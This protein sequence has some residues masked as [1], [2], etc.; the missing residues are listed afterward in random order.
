MNCPGSPAVLRGAI[1][2]QS[3]EGRGERGI[4]GRLGPGKIAYKHRFKQFKTNF[5]EIP[6]VYNTEH[7][8]MY[9]IF[10]KIYFIKLRITAMP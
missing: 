8:Q 4:W 7:F 9:K 10:R 6:T 1:R 3:A 2:V 5:S